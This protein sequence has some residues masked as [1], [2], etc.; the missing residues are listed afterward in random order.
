MPPSSVETAGSESPHAWSLHCCWW[1]YG[2]VQGPWCSGCRKMWS[3]E[4]PISH[5][6]AANEAVQRP[7]FRKIFL[8]HLIAPS[9]TALRPGKQLLRLSDHLRK[10]SKLHSLLPPPSQLVQQTG[11]LSIHVPPGLTPC[12]TQLAAAHH[13]H[14]QQQ[15]Q[16]RRKAGLRSVLPSSRSNSSTQ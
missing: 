9:A 14:Q 11:K 16:E 8:A 2:R 15:Q 5:F 1:C 10:K 13:R 12:G 6:P 4:K 7:Q 3:E